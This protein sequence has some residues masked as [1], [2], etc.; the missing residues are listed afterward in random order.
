MKLHLW[1]IRLIGVIVP[2]RLRADWRQEWEAELQYREALLADWD[3]LDWKNRLDLMRRSLGAFQDALWLQPQRLEDEMVQ[4]LRF[5]AR[6]LVKHQGFAFIA[7]LTLALGIGANTAIF[8]V[9]NAVLLRPLPYKNPAQI[10]TVWEIFP[11]QGNIQNPVAP[12]NFID[13]RE[14]SNSFEALEH[15]TAASGASLT[16][17]GEPEKVNA[18]YTSDG[19]FQLLGVQPELGRTFQRG[20]LTQTDNLAMVVISHRLWQR[21]FAG[22]SD[23]IGKPIRLD[24]SPVTIIGV[25]PAS[26]EYPSANVDVWAAVKLPPQVSGTPQAHYLHVLGRLKPGVSVNQAQTDMDRVAAQLSAQYPQTNK[27]IGVEVKSLAEQLTGDLSRPLF[28]LLAATG[29]VLL[30]ACVNVANLLLA[31]AANRQKEIAIRLAIG[32]GRGRIILQLLTE[33]ALLAVLGGAGG[34]LLAVWGIAILADLTPPSIIQAKAASL[35]VQV[36]LF[37]LAISLLTALLF[38]LVPAWQATKPNLNR[39]LKENSNHISG[40]GRGWTRSLLV[41]SE[42]AL[43]MVL[44]VGGGLLLK[45]FARLSNVNPGFRTSQLLTLEVS[46]PYSKYPDIEKRTAFYDELLQ[47]VKTLPG[48]QAAGLVTALPAKSDLLEMTWITEQKET[49]KV[50]SAVPL[51]ISTDY[52]HTLE[53][54]LVSGRVFDAQ[55][56]ASKAGVVIIN[57]AM[58]A[59]AWPGENPIGKRMKMGLM[60]QP[61]LTVAGVVKDTRL[62]LEKNP[63]P[64]VYLPYTQTPAFGPGDLVLQTASEPTALVAAVRGEVWAI[65]KDQPIAEVQSMEQ[66]LAGSIERPRFHTLLVTIFGVL[67]LMLALIGIFGVMSYTVT[68]NRREIGLRLALGA[69]TR[70]V[71]KLVVK[72]GMTLVL[73]GVAIGLVASLAL[74]RIMK[75]LLFEVTATDPLTFAAIAVLFATVAFVA[76]YFPARRATRIDPLRVL[77]QE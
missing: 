14:Q 7:I 46:P 66:L 68:Q 55:D 24:D 6:M 73:A 30:I 53:I 71:L 35:D 48:V 23:L 57:E 10:M 62:R 77:R 27:Y 28:I 50:I 42:I 39:S 1:L 33:S 74:T 72:Q 49:T 15:H 65:D 31:R 60:T 37:A 17:G 38:G 51:S 18:V 56:T 64:Q 63:A 52:F 12:S 61:W 67:A 45:S 21:R 75:G 25:M 43:A 76:C 36:L 29:L 41:I 59:A 22:A 40:V 34:L 20:E 13:W 70:D 9:V 3:R 26:F 5:G 19:L 47:R 58:A 69:Q 16:D 11:N 2:R 4:D 32:A 44:L 8:S 54:P